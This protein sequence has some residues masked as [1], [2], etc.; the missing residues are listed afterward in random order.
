MLFGVQESQGRYILK[1]NSLE[2]PT[3]PISQ[4]D[5]MVMTPDAQRQRASAENI[6]MANTALSVKH[7]SLCVRKPPG[8]ADRPPVSAARQHWGR[9]R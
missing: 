2:N 3:D 4:Q 9:T 8:R 7:R 6:N 1:V 5:I